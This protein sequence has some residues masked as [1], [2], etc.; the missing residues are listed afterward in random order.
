LWKHLIAKCNVGKLPKA[1]EESVG[2][3][4]ARYFPRLRAFAQAVDAIDDFPETILNLA[5][6]G[7]AEAQTRRPAFLNMTL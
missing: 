5:K 6:S 2:D 7:A 3:L 1:G 4:N